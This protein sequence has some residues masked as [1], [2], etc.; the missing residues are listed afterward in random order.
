[1]L[2]NAFFLN[3]DE[4]DSCELLTTQCLNE[5]TIFIHLLVVTK[6][7]LNGV[8]R[9]S[10]TWVVSSV[11][12][13]QS[14]VKPDN[15]QIGPRKCT[16]NKRKETSSITDNI[17]VLLTL[18]FLRLANIRLVFIPLAFLASKM[19]GRNRTFHKMNCDGKCSPS[20]PLR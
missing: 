12:V 14:V 20:C 8:C 18:H 5:L 1:M 9:N 10:Q 17:L 15:F 4:R 13:I 6:P 3:I 7:I 2:C 16:N 19:P 11:L